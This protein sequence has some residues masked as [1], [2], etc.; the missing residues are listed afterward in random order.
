MITDAPA[1]ASG[2]P[3]APRI[4]Q[5]DIIVVNW[6]NDILVVIVGHMPLPDLPHPQHSSNRSPRLSRRVHVGLAIAATLAVLLVL[7]MI[8]AAGLGTWR[9]SG[10]RADGPELPRLRNVLALKPGMSVADVGAGD[11]ELTAALAAEVGTN[12]RCLL[13]RS[14]TWSRSERR[15][16]PRGCRMSRS[17]SRRPVIRACPRIAATRL[18]CA[19]STTI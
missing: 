18:S 2:T 4:P 15:S 8:I 3:P 6:H 13:E 17:C 19:V 12:G 9:G 14:S 5:V 11:G 16:P 1:D 7:L 10:F